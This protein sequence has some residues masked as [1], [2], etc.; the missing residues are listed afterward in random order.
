MNF[1]VFSYSFPPQSGPESF[2]AARFCSAIADSGHMVHVVTMEHPAEVSQEIVRQLVSPALK[3]SR[4]PIRRTRKHVWSR[5]RYLT[6]EW[7]S[8]NFGAAIDTLA[9]VLRQY[10]NPILVSRSFPESSHVISYYARRLAKK[11]IAHFSDPIPFVFGKDDTI[12]GWLWRKVS[13]RWMR[14]VIKSC[15]AVS[16]TCNDAKRF[17]HETYGALFDAKTVLVNR[18]IGNPPL[19]AGGDWNRTFSEKLI[20]HSGGLNVARGARE[21]VSALDAINGDGVKVRFIQAG[22]CDQE[23]RMLFAERADAEVLDVAQPGLASDVV[24]A[25]DVSLIS[26]VQVPMDYTPFMPSKFV[27]QLFSDKPLVLYSKPGSPMWRAAE[28]YPSAGLFLAD[29]T[30]P[31]TLPS[32]IKRAVNAVFDANMRDCLRREFDKQTVAEHFVSQLDRVL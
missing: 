6:T 21:I 5:L 18:H 11:W 30:I 24:A 22:S 15:D 28:K 2:C 3:I 25:C 23:T 10:E 14:R 13:E 29:Y 26:D 17:Y 20:V 1:V 7:G 8:G 9:S 31:A 32:A 27:Y 19:K 12:K 16:L 4:V